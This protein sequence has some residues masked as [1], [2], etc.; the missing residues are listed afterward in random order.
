M[1]DWFSGSALQWTIVGAVF[2]LLVITAVAIVAGGNRRSV[3]EQAIDDVEEEIQV[4][5]VRAGSTWMG[6]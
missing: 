5:H 6:D 2:T 3:N 1:F 4:R